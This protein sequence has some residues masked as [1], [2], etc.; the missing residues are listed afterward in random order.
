MKKFYVIYQP[1][2]LRNTD[3]HPK[4]CSFYSRAIIDNDGK[5]DVLDVWSAGIHEAHFFEDKTEA[6]LKYN[7]FKEYLPVY[8]QELSFK[9]NM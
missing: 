5:K 4:Q 6:E 9:C 7:E 8:F 1:F 3:S 2:G